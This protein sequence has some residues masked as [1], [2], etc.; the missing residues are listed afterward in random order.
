MACSTTGTNHDIDN[1]FNSISDLL[2]AHSKENFALSIE[3]CVC[4]FMSA[5]PLLIFYSLK[6]A[7][8]KDE[9]TIR[10]VGHFSAKYGYVKVKWLDADFHIC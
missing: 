1:A 4:F 10:R 5:A 8:Q 6:H 7:R 3:R 9:N 2:R